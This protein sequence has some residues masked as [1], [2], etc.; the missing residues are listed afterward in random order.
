MTV[1]FSQVVKDADKF[2]KIMRVPMFRAGDYGDK[3]RYTESDLDAMADSYDTA[4]LEA[5]VTKDHLEWGPAE[6]WIERVY[7][8]GDTLFG[9]W[10]L[11][12]DAFK[13]IQE[14]RYKRRSIEF[15]RK[16]TM[17]DGRVVPYVKACS[18][19]GAATPH[20][21]GMPNIQFSDNAGDSVQFDFE[22]ESG[23]NKEVQKLSEGKPMT[24]IK[25]PAKYA[26]KYASKFTS[27]MTDEQH[28]EVALSILEEIAAENDAAQAKMS[29]LEKTLEEQSKKLSQQDADIANILA[30]NR[31]TKAEKRFAECVSENR[32]KVTPIAERYLKAIF[33]AFAQLPVAEKVAFAES[34]KAEPREMHPSELVL[35]YIKNSETV[36]PLGGG[37]TVQNLHAFNR[38]AKPGRPDAAD[39]EATKKFNEQIMAKAAELQKDNPS[40][41]YGDAM[42]EAER[43]LSA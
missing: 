33:D 28:N 13:E 6:G 23:A 15:Y 3:G 20:C 5:P 2:P 38:G 19:L 1:R 29:E 40:L 25:L 9:D 17:P 21:K 36:V 22:P 24:R 39:V 32:D 26:D 30:D 31:R 35:E 37:A 43:L 27:D 42:I 12:P 4:Y 34:E 7:R 16:H 41:D 14:G 10:V 8:E 11:H 18:I